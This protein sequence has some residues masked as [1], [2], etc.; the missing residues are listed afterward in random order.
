MK[1]D[2]LLLKPLPQKAREALGHAF[3]VHEMLLPEYAFAH[4]RRWSFWA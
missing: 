4:K 3:S 2:C 1:P